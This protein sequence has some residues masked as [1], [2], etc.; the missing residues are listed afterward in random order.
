MGIK[1][2]ILPE[3]F[4]EAKPL[5]EEAF[6]Y[7]SETKCPFA[8]IIRKGLFDDYKLT[9]S[10]STLAY[11]LF[12]KPQNGVM[13]MLMYDVNGQ[14]GPNTW[15]KDVFGLNIYQDR[16]EPFCKNDTIAIQKQECSKEG[17]GLCCSN[18]YLIGG[19]FN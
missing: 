16:F 14:V 10:N 13:G 17:T 5:I 1:Y 6:K 12:D 7:M 15:G 11:K 8:F 9:H 2:E 3:D 19:N 18:Y 4:N